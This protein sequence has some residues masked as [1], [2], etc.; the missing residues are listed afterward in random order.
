M[1]SLASITATARAGSASRETWLAQ[2]TSKG[3][4]LRKHSNMRHATWHMETYRQNRGQTSSQSPWIGASLFHAFM[5][6]SAKRVIAA[7]RTDIASKNLRFL[8]L[9]QLLATSLLPIATGIQPRSV[10]LISNLPID[11]WV[12]NAN[13]P[14]FAPQGSNAGTGFAANLLN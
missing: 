12:S 6:R 10:S 3:S 13:L 9:K 4:A 1:V 11:A 14:I 7:I 2:L 8:R 5:I